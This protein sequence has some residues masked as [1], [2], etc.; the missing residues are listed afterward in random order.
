MKKYEVFR[1][2][3]LQTC[4]D[5]SHVADKIFCFY[6]YMYMHSKTN[7]ALLPAGNAHAITLVAST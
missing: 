5:A 4:I 7:E 3:V 6:M 1:A 2:K